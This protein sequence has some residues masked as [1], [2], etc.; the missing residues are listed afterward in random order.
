MDRL[1]RVLRT[2][3][4]GAALAVGAALIVTHTHAQTVAPEHAT[5]VASLRDSVRSIMA[6]QD[7]PGI[8][9]AVVDPD[10]ILWMEGFGATDA[11]GATPVTPVTLFSVQS[12]SKTFTAL[13]VLTA[14]RDGLLDL[15]TPIT[16]YLPAFSVNSR[17]E[18][19]PEAKMTLRLLLS[20]RAGFTHEA[21]V[22][23]NYADGG[24]PFA[25]HVASI[26]RTWLRFPVGQRYSY[27]NLG[28]DLAGH[29]LEIRSGVPF[30]RYVEEKVLHPL[31]MT[32]STFDQ[33][34]IGRV[35][36]RAIGH[37]RDRDS[38]PCRVPMVAAGGL[39]SN[40]TELARWI[41]FALGGGTAGAEPR[42]SRTLLDEMRVVP[43]RLPRQTHGY[44]LGIATGP[45]Y[46]T[47]ALEHGGGGFGFLSLMQWYPE[48]GIGIVMLTNSSSHRYQRRLPETILEAFLRARLGALPEEAAS[49]EEVPPPAIDVEPSRLRRLAGQ[50]L[51]GSGGYMLVEWED[52]RLGVKPSN[53]LRPF[54]FVAD[55][56]AYVDQGPARFYYLFPPAPERA[57]Q[58]VVRE[59]DATVLDYNVGAD[60]PPGP[61][62]A[63]W[64]PYVGKYAYRAFEHPA[65][66]FE[67]H[68]RGGYLFLDHMK[69][70]EYVPGLFFTANGEALDFREPVPTWRNIPLERD[71]AESAE[72]P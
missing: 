61:D 9:I 58:Q 72:R 49:T 32:S 56:E 39:Y 65:G 46:G 14:V 23:N 30:A 29:I 17:Y 67:V 5:L 48:L 63:A 26:S 21:P 60:D 18:E 10:R 40:V 38:V 3:R 37:T 64:E 71:V 42:I 13:A 50:Y 11:D 57:A 68:R 53:T 15:D 8:A 36:D 52:G 24:Q 70:T 47:Y 41:Q 1:R 55:D 62:L 33:D 54:T 19:R 12:M 44:G 59:Y 2:L 69:L 27:S 28:I 20:H 34:S 7:I 35:V 4:T 25:E 16:E 6:A 43:G 31:G 22:G 45:S 66:S 51:Y